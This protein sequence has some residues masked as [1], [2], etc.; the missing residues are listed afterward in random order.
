MPTALLEN[1][2]GIHEARVDEVLKPG[3]LL[4]GETLL[5]AIGLWV[6]QI[7]F[8]VSDGDDAVAFRGLEKLRVTDGT[9]KGNMDYAVITGVRRG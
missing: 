7:E 8:G 6:G 5:A 1:T 2:E 9:Y 3:P 4:I